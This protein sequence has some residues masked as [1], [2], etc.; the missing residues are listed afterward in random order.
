MWSVNPHT[1]GVYV[2][3]LSKFKKERARLVTKSF[4]L[5]SLLAPRIFHE[6][7]S[8]TTQLSLVEGRMKVNVSCVYN[9]N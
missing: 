4:H 3:V 5:Q 9:S 2:V 6:Q 8:L 1:K 7:E